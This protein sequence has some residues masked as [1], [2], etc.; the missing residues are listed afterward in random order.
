M[1]TRGQNNRVSPNQPFL[2]SEVCV[3]W[4]RARK[5]R[6]TTFVWIRLLEKQLIARMRESARRDDPL[7]QEHAGNQVLLHKIQIPALLLALDSS[8][9][10]RGSTMRNKGEGSNSTSKR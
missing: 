10:K 6:L 1:S 4:G 9:S 3:D 5:M 7:S 8:R 2:T